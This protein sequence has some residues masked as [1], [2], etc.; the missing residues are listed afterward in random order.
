[1]IPQKRLLTRAILR[2]PPQNFANG[3]TTVNL[4]APDYAIALQQH[5]AYGEALRSIGIGLTTL[6]PDEN[7]PDSTFVE[8]TAILTERCAIVTRPGAD[9]R[10]E[11]TEEIAKEFSRSF[12]EISFIEP[13]GTLDGGDVCE[14]GDH[15]FIGI[16]ARTNQAGAQQLA[17]ILRVFDYSSEFI[18]VRNVNNILHLKSGLSYLGENRLVVIDELAGFKE[19]QR[20]ELIRVDRREEYAANCV[21]VNDSI[22]VAAGFPLFIEQLNELGQRT[23]SL[24]MSE[25]Q[26]MDG[27]LSC[28]SLRF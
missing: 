26:K 28:L 4:G 27:G 14:A 20:F 24:E 17:E 21:R 16:S 2:P 12:P 22:L 6:A 13:P 11:E 10:R 15:F 9:S 25:F 8:D 7:Y 18:D 3:L 1:M 19:F 23:V 5:A